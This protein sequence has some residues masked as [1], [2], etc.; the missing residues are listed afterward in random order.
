MAN[1][2]RAVSKYWYNCISLDNVLYIYICPVVGEEFKHVSVGWIEN[3]KE[4]VTA[5]C[6]YCRP[7]VLR[8]ICDDQIGHDCKRI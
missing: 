1:I 4:T 5:T 6:T 8:A 3:T 7:T 2:W